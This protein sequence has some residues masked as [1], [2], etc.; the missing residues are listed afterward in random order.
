MD[1]EQLLTNYKAYA[2]IFSNFILKTDVETVLHIT[3]TQEYKD[4]IDTAF[5]LNE[6]E[7]KERG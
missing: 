3:E 7:K 6:V 2:I 1:K 4:L 5:M